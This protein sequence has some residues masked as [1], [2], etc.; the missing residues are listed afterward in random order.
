MAANLAEVK[1]RTNL[2]DTIDLCWTHQ[3]GLAQGSFPFLSR[4]QTCPF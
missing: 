4:W 1:T 2:A 3:A